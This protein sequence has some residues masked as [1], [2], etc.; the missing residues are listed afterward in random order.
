MTALAGSSNTDYPD[1]VASALGISPGTVD[2][3]LWSLDYARTRRNYNVELNLSHVAEGFRADLGYLPQVGYDQGAFLGEYDFY[4]P[5]AD[6]WQSFGFG[7]ISNWTR[8]TDGGADLDRKVKL[9]TVLHADY[10]A[11]VFL[12]ATHDEQYY[13]GKLFQLDQ[14]EMDTTV[15][16]VSWLNGE[17]D[18]VR[19]DGVDYTGVRKAGLLSVNT[20]LYVQ[21]GRH[22]KVSVVDDYE[23]L[24]FGRRA[25][26][27][28][29][30]LR[31]ATRLV[32]HLRVC[33]R[34]SSDRGRTCATTRRYTPPVPPLAPAPSPRSG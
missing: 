17:V 13:Q 4:A 14:L 32:F 18:V 31:S 10:Q 20:T 9:Y 34:T 29:E 33:S 30:R 7:T 23:Q 28:G 25:A 26:L 15:Q 11:Q 22:L 1:T 8:A 24:D 19:G 6:W 16:P 3:D 2:G 12:Y 21:P 5:D 27:H